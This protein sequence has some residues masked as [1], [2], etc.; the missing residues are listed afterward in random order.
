MCGVTALMRLDGAPVEERVLRRM[1]Q[2]VAHRGPDGEGIWI[3]GSIGLGH[4]RLAIRDLGPTGHQPMI[5]SGG[6]VVLSYNG[7]IYNDKE[8]RVSIQRETGY[9]FLGSSDTEVIVAGWLAW[10]EEVFTRLDGMFAAILWD[11]RTKTLCLA[12]DA[13]GIKPLYRTCTPEFVAVASEIKAILPA[14]KKEPALSASALHAFLAQGY[15]AP[16]RSLYDNIEQ[17]PPGTIE[18][19][20]DRVW[21]Q[22][23]FWEPRRIGGINSLT[24]AASEFVAVWEKTIADVLVSDVPV[25]VLQSG[26]IDSSLVSLMA[27]RTHPGLRLFSAGF[28]EPSHDERKM[29]AISAA[30][31]GSPLTVVPV[32]VDHDAAQLFTSVV[33]H[34]DGQVADASA[35]A[36]F[37]LSRTV[38]QHVKVVLS[39]DGADEFFAGY[40]TY[41]AS[42]A[43]HA[44]RKLVPSSLA[45]I[46]GRGLGALGG[47]NE[48]RLPP[49]QILSRFL[50]G[51][52][53]RQPHTEWRRLVPAFV[54]PD[55]YGPGLMPELAHSPLAGYE[56]AM[57]GETSLDA[58]LL[59]DQ[60]FYLPA[61]MLTK[62]DAM[63]MAHGLEVRVPFLSRSVLDL[64]ARIDAKVLHPLSG[65]PKAPL[66]QAL[67]ILGG[68]K[69]I[70]RAAKRGFNVPV[71]R[72]LRGSLAGL[73]GRLLDREADDLAPWLSPSTV[74]SLWHQHRDNRRSWGY[75]LWPILTFATWRK[76]ASY[77]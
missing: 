62:V 18:V 1:T 27:T 60:N 20:R 70:S 57:K 37:A 43:A 16:T 55:L 25:G 31:S 41:T 38:R 34:F 12:R 4:R 13:V 49:I 33:R 10:G 63:S 73:A 46:F 29:A 74:R 53:G 28:E 45:S 11:R 39:G 44:I 58:C 67:E 2:T 40:T 9:R 35:L 5:S 54:L 19:F 71:D 15:V 59:A 36:V 51:L 17:V 66:R 52:G 65:P 6:D 69:T 8:L 50:L 21:R 56:A 23:T 32:D 75:A 61:D 3:E 68:P 77:G 26:G 64:A 42:Q 72:L 14:L 24:E 48:R 7:E 47:A 30:A 76:T 22:R